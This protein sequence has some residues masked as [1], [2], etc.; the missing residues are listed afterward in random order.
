[1]VDALLP[2]PKVTQVSPTL[3]IYEIP[4]TGE[5]VWVKLIGSPAFIEQALGK[6]TRVI[7]DVS[8]S[9]EELFEKPSTAPDL[10]PDVIVDQFFRVDVENAEADDISVVHMTVSVGKEWIEENDIHTWSIETESPGRREWYLG[11]SS[12]QARRGDSGS[13]NLH[14]GAARVLAVS[15][16]GSK[17]HP[18]AA[19]RHS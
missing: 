5:L 3:A 6:F 4:N 19:V 9:V 2:P 16:Y 1:M 12:N 18:A 8:I 17:R 10:D 7:T 15:N 11:A 13:D 14:G